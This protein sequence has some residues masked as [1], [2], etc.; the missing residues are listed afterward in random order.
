M[1]TIVTGSPALQG[2]DA[3]TALFFHPGLK[4]FGD[5][6]SG[7][8]AADDAQRSAGQD[9]AAVGPSPV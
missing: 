1:L 4:P 3:G 5:A 7:V 6:A 2:F 9:G 8:G